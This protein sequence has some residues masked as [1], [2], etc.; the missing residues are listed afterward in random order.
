M[1]SSFTRTRIIIHHDIWM[2]VASTN[3]TANSF[4]TSLRCDWLICDGPMGDHSIDCRLLPRI[5]FLVFSMCWNSVQS[6]HRYCIF[7]LKSSHPSVTHSVAQTIAESNP[8]LNLVGFEPDIHR[9]TA[10][11]TLHLEP[12]VEFLECGGDHDD[13]LIQPKELLSFLTE[14]S[15]TELCTSHL[16][17]SY[18]R[19]SVIDL[20]VPYK[21]SLDK[22]RVF[23]NDSNL[24][25]TVC[26]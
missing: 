12:R 20:S 6:H 25:A 14:S 15:L 10:C 23:F 8:L 7:T 16:K 1:P 19:N 2:P 13:R 21:E 17:T 24:L 3:R 26:T 18:I 5:R 9:L 22:S 4:F 11:S